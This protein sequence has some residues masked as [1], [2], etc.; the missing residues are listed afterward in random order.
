VIVLLSNQ[1]ERRMQPG[2]AD[3]RIRRATRAD[4]D[5]LV[6]IEERA[7]TTDRIPRRSFRRFV[8]S[9]SSA[10]L[11]AV[12]ERTLVGYAL[13][14]FRAGA[15]VARLYS[16]ATAPEVSRRGIG[17][18][19]LAAA[20]AAARTRKRTVLRLEVHEKNAAAIRL[21]RKA[22]YAMFGRLSHY[23]VDRG[24]ALRFEKSL[25]AR[26]AKSPRRGK[27]AGPSAR[28]RVGP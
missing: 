19:L 17:V 16:I 28:R 1:M 10:L 26:P 27:R 6:R 13:V 8:T 12:R 18:A 22:G 11:V 15:A 9:R 3:L 21:Y 4:V 25:T 5:G 23:Y 24:D 7:F 2:P 14:L 20:E